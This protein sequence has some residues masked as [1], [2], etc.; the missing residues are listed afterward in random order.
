MIPKTRVNEDYII[1]IK[2]SIK[3]S[4]ATFNFCFLRTEPINPPFS[5]A[6]FVQGKVG[7]P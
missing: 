1:L 5:I 2:S 3:T 6:V 7:Q 4:T